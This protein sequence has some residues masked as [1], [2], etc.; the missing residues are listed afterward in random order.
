VSGEVVR[1]NKALADKPEQVNTAPH[2]SWMV[3]L[4]LSNP[5]EVNTLLDAAQYAELAK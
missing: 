4:K 1:V 5:S 2:E 3:T